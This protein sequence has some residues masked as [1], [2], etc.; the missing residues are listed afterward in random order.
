MNGKNEKRYW[1]ETVARD[2]PSASPPREHQT[3]QRPRRSRPTTAGAASA[4]PR[5]RASR[6]TRGQH[7]VL[8]LIGSATALVPYSCPEA[9]ERHERGE[10]HVIAAARRIVR[11]PRERRCQATARRGPGHEHRRWKKPRGSHQDPGDPRARP[12]K[13]PGSRPAPPGGELDEGVEA[14]GLGPLELPG[15]H[16]RTG[17]PCRPRAGEGPDAQ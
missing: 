3:H 1:A 6:T 13:R 8:E 15:A 10:E 4:S 5:G 7:E 12:A 16:R 9:T 11:S 2:R 17:P 14:S